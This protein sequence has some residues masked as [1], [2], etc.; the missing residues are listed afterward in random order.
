MEPVKI[1]CISDTHTLHNR[2][3]IEPCDILIHAG[4]L[5]GRGSPNESHTAIR[6]LEKQPAKNVIFIAGNHELGWDKSPT[7]DWLIDLLDSMK[8]NMYY[9]RDGG[10]EIM[11]IKFWGTPWQPEFFNWAFN[12]PRGEKLAEKYA[13][14]PQDTDILISHGPPY[15]MFDEIPKSYLQPGETDIHKG[16]VDL[17]ARIL[18]LS[19]KAHIFGHI[20]LDGRKAIEPAYVLD[21]N[22]LQKLPMYINAAVVDNQYKVIVKPYYFTYE[23]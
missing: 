3:K 12:L 7:P 15:G 17:E 11:G 22:G 4:D 1:C 20:H 14:I 2:L 10:I 5:T 21:C 18:K 6:W 9:L 8:D 19:L 23:S 13:L 16:C